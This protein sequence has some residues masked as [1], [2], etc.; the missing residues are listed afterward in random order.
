MATNIQ[1]ANVRVI[2][3]EFVLDARVE[4]ARPFLVTGF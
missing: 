2:T 4:L 1:N 3:I